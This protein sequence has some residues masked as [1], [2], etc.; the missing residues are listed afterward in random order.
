MDSAWVSAF[1][2]RGL[3]GSDHFDADQLDQD[4]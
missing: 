1:I 4:S 2:V 3:P